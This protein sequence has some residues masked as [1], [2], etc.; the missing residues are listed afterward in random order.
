MHRANAAVKLPT[1][2]PCPS[3]PDAEAPA[4]TE[5]A[6]PVALARWSGDRPAG[7]GPPSQPVTKNRAVR[8]IRAVR[9]AIAEIL[10]SVPGRGRRRRY[11]RAGTATGTDA[12]TAVL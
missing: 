4:R 8:A 11:G 1:D 7:G 5:P 10:P 9:V 2:P 3:E 12:V 6:L